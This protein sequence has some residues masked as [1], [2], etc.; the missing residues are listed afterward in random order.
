MRREPDD[1]A[2]PRGHSGDRAASHSTRRAAAIAASA[3]NDAMAH[4]AASMSDCASVLDNRPDVRIAV[5]SL[6]RA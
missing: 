4:C 5:T 3:Y 2:K 6:I 1:S